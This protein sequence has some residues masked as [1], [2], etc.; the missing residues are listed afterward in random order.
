M[1][2]KRFTKEQIAC[3]LALRLGAGVDGLD[4]RRDLPQARR[5]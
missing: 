4:D 1:K 2:K 5:V 3:A